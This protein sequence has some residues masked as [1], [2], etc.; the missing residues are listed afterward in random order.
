MGGYWDI[1]VY[2]GIHENEGHAVIGIDYATTQSRNFSN[3][4][5]KMMH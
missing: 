2:D 3:L 1:V 4:N 5:Q